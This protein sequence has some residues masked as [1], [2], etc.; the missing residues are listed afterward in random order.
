MPHVHTRY[1]SGMVLRA[2]PCLL[3][4]DPD[5]RNNF[6]AHRPRCYVRSA[7]CLG[8]LCFAQTAYVSFGSCRMLPQK[9]LTPSGPPQ[10]FFP[11]CSRACQACLY[12]PLKW[13]SWAAYCRARQLLPP[14]SGPLI[15]KKLKS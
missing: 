14:E 2:W 7:D 1:P 5:G 13:G 3:L 4:L 8:G 15:P 10:R 12:C 9:L 6:I 11:A